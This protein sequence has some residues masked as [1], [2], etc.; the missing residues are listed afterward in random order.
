M[1]LLKYKSETPETLETWH[2][3]WPRPTRWETAVA[4]KLK[5]G[6]RQEQRRSVHPSADAGL[7]FLSWCLLSAMGDD[8]QTGDDLLLVALGCW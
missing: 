1:K 3:R 4:S 7:P 8:V 5:S 6:R 2:H